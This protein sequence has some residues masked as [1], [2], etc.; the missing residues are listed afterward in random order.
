[1]CA[2]ERTSTT[3][4]QKP[5]SADIAG[6]W[7]V[8]VADVVRVLILAFGILGFSVALATVLAKAASAI[9]AT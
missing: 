4:D 6:W 9:G 7:L 8:Y 5:D 3:P 2:S 1:M